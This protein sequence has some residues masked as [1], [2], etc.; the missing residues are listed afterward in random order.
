M[1]TV[2]LDLAGLVLILIYLLDG[3]RKRV[4]EKD[5]GRMFIIDSILM[6][7]SGEF[8]RHFRLKNRLSERWLACITSRVALHWQGCS[9]L[10][11]L[12]LASVAQQVCSS[13]KRW[14]VVFHLHGFSCLERWMDGGSSAQLY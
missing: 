14:V 4:Y 10:E 1:F 7:V 11:G 3:P 9:R 13:L 8:L 5:T 12:A 2:L 6:L